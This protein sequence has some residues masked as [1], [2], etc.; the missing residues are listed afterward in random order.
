MLR[1][2]DRETRPF[3]RVDRLTV[4]T[5]V[6]DLRR[7]S[8]RHGLEPFHE[9]RFWRCGGRRGD[10]VGYLNSRVDAEGT[11]EGVPCPNFR[12]S[13]LGNVFVVQERGKNAREEGIAAIVRN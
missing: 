13:G 6:P 9:L 12:Y 4:D 8:V 7:R 1:P 3:H 2:N 5:P 10:V 11:T